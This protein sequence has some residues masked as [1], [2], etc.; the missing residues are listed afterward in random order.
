M[1]SKQLFDLLGK[2]DEKYIS[3]ALLDEPCEKSGSAGKFDGKIADGVPLDK[4]CE[5]EPIK[6]Q[7]EQ[8]TFS[9]LRIIAPIA[10]C[11]ALIAGLA[12]FIPKITFIGT[13]STPAASVSE[14]GGKIN[15]NEL[16]NDVKSRIITERP[17]IKP[18]EVRFSPKDNACFYLRKTS[19][20]K[21]TTYAVKTLYIIGDKLFESSVLEH[22]ALNNKDTYFKNSA[23]VSEEEFYGELIYY[24]N[25]LRDDNANQSE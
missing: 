25:L 10:A 16:L 22:R 21:Q 23:E 1:N 13:T 15:E 3:E 18:D 14:S 19:L 4:L 12:H 9:P 17:D 20:E 24:T 7:I 8:T 5:S 11:L 2:I 6:V